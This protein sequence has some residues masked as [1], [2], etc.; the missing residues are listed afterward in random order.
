MHIMNEG[1]ITVN[2][3]HRIKQGLRL[4]VFVKAYRLH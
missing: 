1:L 2:H 4:Y 3:G